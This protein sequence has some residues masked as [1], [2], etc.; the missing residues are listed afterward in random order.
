MAFSLLSTK[1]LLGLFILELSGFSEVFSALQSSGKGFQKPICQKF[2]REFEKQSKE[3]R[4]CS[5]NVDP[6]CA[7]NRQTYRNPCEF[8]L[9]YKYLQATIYFMHYGDC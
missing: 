7:S 9:A 4:K 3:E 6:I 5:P 8:C 2:L 1:I